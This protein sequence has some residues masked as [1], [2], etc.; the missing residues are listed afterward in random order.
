MSVP[1]LTTGFKVSR[2]PQPWS[3]CDSRIQTAIQK[4]H[5]VFGAAGVRASPE[6]QISKTVKKYLDPVFV[7]YASRVSSSVSFGPFSNFLA[8]DLNQSDL[9][10]AEWGRLLLRS[11]EFNGNVDTSD[12]GQAVATIGSLREFNRLCHSFTKSSTPVRRLVD[13]SRQKIADLDKKSTGRQ[14]KHDANLSSNLWFQHHPWCELCTRLVEVEEH[15]LSLPLQPREISNL[16]LLA[17]NLSPTYCADHNP[18]FGDKYQK[19]HDRRLHFFAMM[20]LIIFVRTFNRLRAMDPETLRAVAHAITFQHGYRPRSF[21][22]LV[23]LLQVQD[24]HATTFGDESRTKLLD[25]WDEIL[26]MS[27]VRG[28]QFFSAAKLGVRNRRF[29]VAHLSRSSGP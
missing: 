1:K 12:M 14:T 5:L 8:R 3:A 24:A 28:V 20:R 6:R 29:F 19:D 26:S 7:E 9:L 27:R 10:I 16:P 2:F 15:K 4:C 25:L 21:K 11:L 22:R 18:A 13:S 17:R 23:N